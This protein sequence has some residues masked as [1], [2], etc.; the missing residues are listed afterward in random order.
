MTV[1]E[2][3]KQLE[4]LEDKSLSVEVS[5]DMSTCEDDADHR[6]YGEV[7][8]VLNQGNFVTIICENGER[9]Y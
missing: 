4:D 7:L 9:N 3:I 5:V 2:L 1:Q 6:V 8:H